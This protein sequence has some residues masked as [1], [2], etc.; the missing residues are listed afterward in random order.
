MATKM[1]TGVVCVAILALGR[2]AL[3]TPVIKD[4][5]SKGGTPQHKADERDLIY[6]VRQ[7]DSITFSITTAKACE[8]GW[9]IRKGSG[10]LATQ[11][12]KGVKHS[13]FKWKVPNEKANWDIEVSAYGR[14][15]KTGPI[16]HKAQ[17]TWNITTSTV[18]TIKPGQSIQKA[19]DAL[20]PTGGIVELAAGAF[21]VTGKIP[22][23]IKKNNVAVIGQGMDKTELVCSAFPPGPVNALFYAVDVKDIGIEKMYIHSTVPNGAS[24]K[25]NLAIHLRR[26]SN[27]V[28]SRVKVS[29]F[30]GGLQTN[31]GDNE[32]SWNVNHLTVSDCIFTKNYCGSG[33]VFTINSKFL[34][35]IFSYSVSHCGLEFNSGCDNNIIEGNIAHHNQYGFKF[36]VGNDKNIWRNN[37]AYGNQAGIYGQHAGWNNHITNNLFYN[38]RGWGVA[39]DGPHSPTIFVESNTIVLNGVGI[40]CLGGYSIDAKNN[41][42]ANNKSYGIEGAKISSTHNNVWKNKKGNY[43]GI[44][45]GKGDI[46]LAPLF[47][48]PAEGDF[49]LKSKAGRWDPKTKKWVKDAVTSPCIDSGDPKSK[50][51]NES[52]PNGG[53][54]NMGAYGNTI[55][56]S[57]SIYP[58]SKDTEP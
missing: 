18:K 53:R 4:F 17:K 28:I 42:I 24:I 49:H 12:N 50:Y 31:F 44:K 47:A 14:I 56:A 35:N 27:V 32:K 7:G 54:I 25:T 16:P 36:Y 58:K 2:L 22:I 30:R 33:N 43:R 29:H 38:N 8:H 1:K 41:I 3:A 52:Q 5:S 23:V 51:G 37:T 39:I 20:G 57:R 45:K 21:D 9:S 10:V 55:E 19:I 40:C 26:V 11:T 13:T 6:L 48:N 34:R 46:S 15:R